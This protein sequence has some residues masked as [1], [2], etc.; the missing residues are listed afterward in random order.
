[1]NSF[2]QT[3][4]R[5]L[6]MVLVM[7][8]LVSVADIGFVAR[9]NAATN[10]ETVSYGS[11]IVNSVDGLDEAVKNV[12]KSGLLAGG[13]VTY[14]KPSADNSDNVISVDEENRKITVSSFTDDHGNEWMATACRVV[15]EGGK[16]DVTL[17]AGVGSFI[18]EGDAYSVEADFELTKAA[19]ADLTSKLLNA[20]YWLAKGVNNMDVLSSSDVQST[21]QVL[22]DNKNMLEILTNGYTI[23]G[24]TWVIT[25][26]GCKE[27]AKNMI[28]QIDANGGKLDMQVLAENYKASLSKVAYLMA[29][30]GSMKESASQTHTDIS[31]ILIVLKTHKTNIVSTGVITEEQ[32]NTVINSLESWLTTVQPVVDDPWTILGNTDVLKSDMTDAEYVVLDSLV[33][34]VALTEYAGEIP[35]TLKVANATVSAETNR[36]TVTVKVEAQVIPK[37]AVDSDATTKLGVVSAEFKMNAGTSGTDILAKINELGVEAGAL[38][39]WDAFYAVNTTNYVRAVTNLPD[40]LEEDIT[41]T[42]TYTPKAMTVA[43]GEGCDEWTDK[44]TSVPYGYQMKLPV[45]IGEQVYDY[46]VN[47]NDA[48]Q[49]SVIRITGATTISRS[50][51]KAWESHSLG[52]LI[53]D[54]FASADAAARNIL[55]SP[56]LNTGAFRLRTPGA[57]DN[58]LTLD[59]ETGDY[60]VTALTYLANTSGLLWQPVSAI[61]SGGE[62]DGEVVSFVSE[63]GVYTATIAGSRSF[64]KVLVN[65]QVALS[66]DVLGISAKAAST[67]LNLPYTLTTDASSQL[68]AM[69][70]L[71]GQYSNIVMLNDNLNAIKVGV[72]G[73]E[74]PQDCKDAVKDLVDNC[75]NGTTL[76]LYSH[77]TAYRACGSDAEKLAYYYRNYDGE[78]GL[79]AQINRIVADFKVLAVD[80][81]EAFEAFL[82]SMNYGEY[83]GKIETIYNSL[84]AVQ[85]SMVAPNAAI[86]LASSS[87]NDLTG[88]VVENLGHTQAYNGTLDT[89]VLNTEL[90]VDAP[91]KI[92]VTITVQKVNSDGV[93]IG[94]NSESISF[95]ADL[96]R[97]TLTAAQAEQLN[98]LKAELYGSLLTTDAD[99]RHYATVNGDRTFADGDEITGANNSLTVSY[100]PTKYTV[101]FVDESGAPIESVTFP[102]DN[103]TIKLPACEDGV[104][105]WDYRI[106]GQWKSDA[107]YTFSEAQ[108]DSLFAGNVYTITRRTVNESREKID[109]LV[110]QL[111]QA[112]VDANLIFTHNGRPCL[113]ASVIPVEHDGQ[114]S[115]VL[116]ISPEGKAKVQDGLAKVAEVL[117]NT[118]FD[119]VGIGDGPLKANDQIHLQG[120]IDAVLNS[121]MGLNTITGMIDANG[122]L[123]EMT[124]PGSPVG[125]DANNAI[126]VGSAFIAEANLYGAKM[127]ETTLF[128]GTSAEA[129]T[130]LPL[131]LTME[132]FDRAAS[133]LL[134]ARNAAAAM[135]QYVDITAADGR[136]NLT[137][138]LTDGQYA[139]VISGMLATGLA[140]K[141][142]LT[143]VDPVALVHYVYN[144]LKKPL[145]D[146]NV[147]AT[148][149]NNSLSKLGVNADL[150]VYNDL[151]PVLRNLMNNTTVSNEIGETDTYKATLTYDLS[152]LIEKLNLSAM[153]GVIAE[154]EGGL[155]LGVSLKVENLGKSYTAMVIDTG[156]RGLSILRYYTTSAQLQ[157]AV[158][159]LNA[160]SV[161][162]LMSDY[163]G[164]LNINSSSVILDL[165]GKTINGDLIATAT[166]VIVDSS[167][168]NSGSITGNVTGN[169]KIT[170]GHY[171]ADVSGFLPANGYKLVDG[172]VV[173]E[174]Y[175]WIE[176]E[177]GNYTIV[178]NADMLKM[179][180]MPS[181]KA[182]GLE[183]TY[184]AILKHFACAS[185][186]F[187]GNQIYSIEVNDLINIV[188][189]G[190]NAALANDLL[191]CIKSDGITAFANDLLNVLTDFKA[192][193]EA[194]ANDGVIKTFE[195]ITGAWTISLDRVAE[196]DYLTASIVPS[197]DTVSRNV[198]LK[199]LDN[200]NGDFAALVDKMK[201]VVD[202]DANVN[203]DDL[204]FADGSVNVSGSGSVNAVLNLH[205]DADYGAVVAVLLAN[206]T[207]GDVRANLINALQTYVNT[208]K[209]GAM[210]DAVEVVT[211]AKLVS[212]LK[213]LQR[214]SFT[215]I[216]EALGLTGLNKAADLEAAYD[217]LLVMAGNIASALDITGNDRT[218]GSFSD[219]YGSYYVG[220]VFRPSVNGRVNLSA[221]LD[222]QIRLNLFRPDPE[223][224]IVV[225][226]SGVQEYAGESLADAFAAASDGSVIRIYAPVALI[227]DVTVS[228]NITVI[229]AGF[230]TQISE[231]N[232]AVGGTL[233]TDEALKVTTKE[234][235][236]EVVRSDD[237]IYSLSALKP[238]I[239]APIVVDEENVDSNVVAGYQV[240][241]EKNM[242]VLD[243]DPSEGITAEQVVNML[244]ASASNASDVTIQVN[245]IGI[246]NGIVVNGAILTVTAHNPATSEVDIKKYTIIIMGDTNCDGITNA[247]D[248]VVMTNIYLYGT[249]VPECV[250]LAADMNQ[251][252]MLDAGDA[253][254][255]QMK[256]LH[257]WVDG[258]Y[259]SALN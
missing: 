255:N 258:S 174:L 30:G 105:R 148:T 156:A 130:K 229:G 61:L 194:M 145:L 97:L 13:T 186:A 259:T 139:A 52:K 207:S 51:G 147:T 253:V 197:S 236:Y 254:K 33:A 47:G 38:N 79:K 146:K 240:N 154:S 68:G 104:N 98:G 62:A 204:T 60:V 212:T 110:A 215:D 143:N 82:T 42:I 249:V 107:S 27:N 213:N 23:P 247:D 59:T 96:G 109:K 83:A 28:D 167:K 231:I 134:G 124:L 190:A 14:Q 100:A 203:L 184:D 140:S 199:I 198:T 73:S 103:P 102:F 165:N 173:N 112:M 237:G 179:D 78:T 9:A 162:V 178:L 196:G 131:Y 12:L 159:S 74:L 163:E 10:D 202:I 37:T 69:N 70:D 246:K 15:Y 90:S 26:D 65:Y 150:A 181:V 2:K 113:M 235:Y 87:L 177:N 8:M 64:D 67:I 226:N 224:S 18:Y 58:L 210:R 48:D 22:V 233:Q 152:Q 111:N 149:L 256:Y 45:N 137:V 136:F 6:A 127:M 218:I 228:T 180:K 44:L 257:L 95:P 56:A 46:K 19:D 4:K 76:Y 248:A 71:T 53:A 243:V 66:W 158:S 227:D 189:N 191:A 206:Q 11:V 208:G 223:S 85:S 39:G 187:D 40:T 205:N 142:D 25:F 252:G 195:M 169:V 122:N 168:M 116:R 171:T 88:L 234:A 72:N 164:D 126:A 63:N 106:D 238:V 201:D 209:T 200:A 43:Y 21:L 183:L 20:P 188:Q 251:N 138:K 129:G 108:I 161:I 176:D 185:V 244:S 153:A 241:T 54:N 221:E 141:D 99:K 81:K 80:N 121:G 155:N 57:S 16:E 132:D 49:G 133:A 41:Y 217:D 230:V 222:V 220:K 5:C 93:V 232:L 50:L 117:V 86:N 36:F 214:D 94:Q 115:L 157:T 144:I 151:I 29:S 219:S 170:A 225:T 123:N 34:D 3:M 92:S 91:N 7:A 245:D 216:L 242:L 160:S 166:T 250:K 77:L 55:V 32:L 175:Q 128:L 101:S 182:L 211:I 114:L 125:M 31:N 84:I 24:T 120:L 172:K 193:S 118:S 75:S 35:T 239:S 89:P 119:Y 135:Q 192:M 17:T 1:M